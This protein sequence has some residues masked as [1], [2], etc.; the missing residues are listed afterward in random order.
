MD[1]PSLPA[2]P[3]EQALRGLERIN[4]WSGSAHIL[5]GPIRQLAAERPGQPLRL[6]DV[7]SGAGDVLLGLARRARRAGVPLDLHGCDLSATALE[8]ARRRAA[9][10][11]LP[12]T[13]V[14]RDVLTEPLPAGFDVV[15]TS[16]FVH[17]LTDGQAV[18]LLKSMA[19]STS[20]LVLVNDLRRCA[21]GLALAHVACRLLSRSPVVHTDGPRSVAA[22]FTPDE[23]RRL[24]E[25]A[26]LHGATVT[27]RW[28][29]RFLLAWDKAHSARS[30]PGV[31]A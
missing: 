20:R 4:W 19:E 13:L 3:H 14:R 27:R 5:W 1:D 24:A 12:I 18:G 10:H 2:A 11:G 29:F 30:G 25:R 9:A 23:A 26:G 16:L 21:R 6:L 22:A 17:H 8:H 28:P 31:V 15:T 7:A